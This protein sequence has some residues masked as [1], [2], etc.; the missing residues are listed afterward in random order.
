MTYP[1]GGPD[2][3][4]PF[5]HQPS[6][7]DSSPGFAVPGYGAPQPN[8]IPHQYGRAAPVPEQPLVVI[9]DITC[10]Q[11]L[12]ITPSGTCPIAGTQWVVTDMSVSTERMSQTGLVL[13]IVGFFMVCFLSLLFLLMK[14]RRTTGYIQVTVRGAGGFMHVTNIP[15]YTPVTM[16]DV[17]GRVNYARTLA[18]MA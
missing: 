4:T 2:G 18:A 7:Y 15:A 3:T 14:E 6:E 17:S 10:T 9:G 1:G 12:V 8:P 11:N 13:A 5:P 16:G